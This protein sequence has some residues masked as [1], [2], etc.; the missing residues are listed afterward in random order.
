MGQVPLKGTCLDH[1]IVCVSGG[2]RQPDILPAGDVAAVVFVAAGS[3]HR[4]V[5]FKP[6]GVIAA[7]ADGDDVSPAGDIALAV[8]VQANVS[9]TVIHKI[10]VQQGA[11][12][13]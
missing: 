11:A 9:S 13:E 10:S 1:V 7:G 6:H 8:I 4:A 5:R 3:D 2:L 12:Q